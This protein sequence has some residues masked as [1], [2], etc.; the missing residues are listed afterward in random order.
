MADMNKFLRGIAFGALFL[1]AVSLA[2]ANEA[3]QLKRQDR[4]FLQATAYAPAAA[5]CRGIAIISPGAGGT[6]QGYRYLGEALSSL[7]YLS[8]VVGHQESGRRAL[9]EHLRGNG[10]REGLAELITEPDAYRGRFMDIAASMQWAEGRC[11]SSE[12]LLIGHSMGAA[13]VMIEAGAKNKIGVSGTDSFNA[14]IALSP[15]GTGSI[16]PENAWSG[17]RRPVLLITGTRDTELGGASW[18]TR[19]EPFRNMP[20]GCKWLGIMDGA[21]HLNLQATGCHVRPRRSQCRLS[22][23][24]SMAFTRVTAV[25][26]AESQAWIY[27][28]S[29]F[30]RGQQPTRGN[31]MC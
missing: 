15:Q 10:L 28:R 3:L 1:G 18:E 20:P 16:F 23:H 6:E 21:S 25:L 2:C 5:T 4:K 19:T 26:G 7:G 30:P 12:K 17:I 29:R 24:F 22:A 27:Q 31:L 11:N 8:V 13:T 14:Y 9:R